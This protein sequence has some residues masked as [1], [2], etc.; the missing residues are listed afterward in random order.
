MQMEIDLL[1][2]ACTKKGRLAVQRIILA[3]WSKR[4]PK[5]LGEPT[6]A[7]MG[8][9]FPS[10][11]KLSHSCQLTENM[12]SKVRAAPGRGQSHPIFEARAGKLSLPEA[13]SCIYLP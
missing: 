8:F 2:N 5:L 3:R 10:P 7:V 6:V 13:Q 12:L 11:I 4:G 1:S 9:H